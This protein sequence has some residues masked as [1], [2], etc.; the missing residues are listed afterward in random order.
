[1]PYKP[2]KEITKAAIQ[3]GAAKASLRPGHALVGSFL[4]GAYIA[5][6]GLLAITVSSGMD[7]KLWGTLPTL[8]SGA[9]FALGLILVIIAG[10]ELLTGNM[11]LLPMAVVRGRISPA[12]LGFNWTL[13]LIGNLMGSLFV[14]YSLAVQAG[15]V[16][17]EPLLT[18][19]ADIATKKGVEETEWQIFLR[20]LGC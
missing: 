10:S 12:K 7:P 9:V 2:P 14:A 5:M 18:R 15:I 3:T 1:M 8:F 11:A 13:V 17:A 6:A 4:A 16:T 19:L 20:A